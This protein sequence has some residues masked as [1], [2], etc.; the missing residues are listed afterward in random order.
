M[1]GITGIILLLTE[2][3]ELLLKANEINRAYRIK[4]IIN[5]FETA[6]PEEWKSLTRK[7][8]NIFG[9]SGSFSDLVIY[10]NNN[11]DVE[12]NDIFNN[13]RIKL[14]EKLINLPS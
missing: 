12:M 2:M 14:H 5:E 7:P 3:H 13:L 9:G 8:L 6:S 1:R 10:I 4:Q 11:P